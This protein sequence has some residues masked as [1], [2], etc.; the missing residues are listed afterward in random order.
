MQV[1]PKV[2]GIIMSSAVGLSMSFFLSFFMLVVGVGFVEGFLLLWL[3]SFV[4]AFVVSVPVAL[5]AIPMTEKVVL[6]MFKVSE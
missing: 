5:V 3:R 1:S 2:F 4:T 6:R